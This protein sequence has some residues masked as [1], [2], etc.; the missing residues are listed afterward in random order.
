MKQIH[1]YILAIA[2]MVIGFA[3][4]VLAWTDVIDFPF[5]DWIGWIIFAIG[6]YFFNIANQ[7][8]Q[9]KLAFFNF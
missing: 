3:W 2:L 8:E 7:I 5:A 4:V 6:G 1:Y 9:K